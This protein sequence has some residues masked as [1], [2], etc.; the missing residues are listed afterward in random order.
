MLTIKLQNDE[1]CVTL[2][3][4]VLY[5]IIVMS[6]SIKIKKG[7]DLKIAGAVSQGAD[8]VEIKPEMVAIYPDDYYGITP[9]P[10]VKEGETVMAGAPLFHDKKYENV[11]VVSPVTGVVKAVERGE[12]R[13][14]IKFVV[15][16]DGRAE[17]KHFDVKTDSA[18]SI[19]NLLA[20][21]GLF[22]MIRQRPYGIV[23][24]FDVQPRDIFI[25]GFD[26][27]PLA[28]DY[29]VL[30]SGKEK[31]LEQ[32]VKMLSALTSGKVYFS[33]R[34]GTFA[35]P[36]VEMVEIEGPHPASNASVMINHVAPVNK[37]ETVWVFD[38]VTVARIGALALNGT[39]DFT[40]T[41][42]LTGSEIK[43][44]H[45]V[46]T[47][48][49]TDLAGVLKNQ[50]SE[51]ESHKR[52]IAGNVLTGTA[53]SMSGFI[54]YPYRQVTVIP[55]GDDVDEFMGWASIA[56]SKMSVSRSFPGHFLHRLFKPDARLNGGRRAMI[57][58]GEYDSVMPMDILPE[59]LIKA[60]LSR[61]IDQMEELGIY[62]IV[63][64]DFALAEYVDTSKL[65]LQK[66]VAEG[67]D[68]LRKELE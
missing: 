44:P 67:I 63:P 46:K 43:A 60:I 15:E 45:Y 28:P 14:I 31:E 17:V 40:A 56:P 12:R 49:G 47:V 22:A 61:N 55:E 26:S 37:G 23:P 7:L 19:K 20:E 6:I 57:M 30:L 68:Y 29:Q 13:K 53:E 38:A 5:N 39:P 9:K 3:S 59:Y 58:S 25:T 2:Q 1:F 65:E 11:K 35:I 52:I 51:S 42:A 21:S 64:E 34:P 54:H 27:A 4:H 18:E 62:E 48:I 32:G 8:S 33:C 24:K 66:I 16:P 50:I 10:E 36:G 41:L